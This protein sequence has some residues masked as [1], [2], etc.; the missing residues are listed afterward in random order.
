MKKTIKMSLM[1]DSTRTT[2]LNPRT[3]V[4]RVEKP[5]FMMIPIFPITPLDD[6]RSDRTRSFYI[7]FFPQDWKIL[8]SKWP[9]ETREKEVNLKESGL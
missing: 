7:Q 3:I 2:K 8:R 6:L 1:N 4:T 5:I 9:M